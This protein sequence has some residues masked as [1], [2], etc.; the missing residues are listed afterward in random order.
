MSEPTSTVT[1]KLPVAI[2]ERLDD[3]AKKTS[4]PRSRLAADAIS[5]YI[6]LQD[7]QI[8]EI[9]KGIREADAG[10]FASEQEVAAVFAKYAR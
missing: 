6:E 1:I 10:E 5:S 9:G 2:K 4:Q 8:E 3:L 7:W